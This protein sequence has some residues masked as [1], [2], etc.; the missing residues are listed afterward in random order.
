M[1]LGDVSRYF[2]AQNSTRNACMQK[3]WSSPRHRRASVFTVP[4]SFRALACS[5]RLPRFPRAIRLLPIP[6]SSSKYLCLVPRVLGTNWKRK[7]RRK[8][9]GT[10]VR[11]SVEHDFFG[12]GGGGSSKKPTMGRMKSFRGS[13]HLPSDHRSFSPSPSRNFSIDVAQ[14]SIL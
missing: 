3:S 12:I 14:M 7:R 10:M 1:T 6:A 8:M 2:C 5:P 9:S 13:R 4:F 11:A